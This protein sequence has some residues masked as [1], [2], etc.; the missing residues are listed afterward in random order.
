MFEVRVYGKICVVV[1]VLVVFVVSVVLVVFVVSL[2]LF[3]W[4]L[5]FSPIGTHESSSL[6]QPCSELQ[7]VWSGHFL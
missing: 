1:D 7:P 2:L 3:L 4:L 5:W 6:V